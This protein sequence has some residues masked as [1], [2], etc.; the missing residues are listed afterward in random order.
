M[1]NTFCTLYEIVRLV[2]TIIW[3]SSQ[4]ILFYFTCFV[5]GC[6]TAWDVQWDR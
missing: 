3:I 1:Y 5:W 2:I 4:L 6:T